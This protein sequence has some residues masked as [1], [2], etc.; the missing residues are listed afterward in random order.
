MMSILR[1]LVL[2]VGI[3]GLFSAGCAPE[4]ETAQTPEAST[5][6]ASTSPPAEAPAPAAGASA[7]LAIELRRHESELAQ[8]VEQ[9][10]LGA[11]HD[12]VDALGA[13]LTAAPERATDLP[14]RSR[15]QL[16]QR[17]ASAKKMADAV[18][19]AGD[20]GD[21]SAAKTHLG[22]L[23]AELLAVVKILDARP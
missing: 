10:R 12:H 14:E 15:T 23:Q 1:V 18:H 8:A 4:D 22:H 6:P 13:L 17:T 3:I 9:G 16:R 5:P 2:A 20:A 19:D 21:L 11:L 7:Q